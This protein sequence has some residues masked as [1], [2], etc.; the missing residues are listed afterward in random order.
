MKH[1]ECRLKLSIIAM[2]IF[3]SAIS[4]KAQFYTVTKTGIDTSKEVLS[5][6]YTS[7]KQRNSNPEEAVIFKSQPSSPYQKR[8]G[9]TRTGIKN[10]PHKKSLTQRERSL[11]IDHSL[12]RLPLS[13]PNIVIA[14]K[15]YNIQHPKIVLAQAIQETGWLNSNVCKTKNN[16]F[17]LTNP[18]TGEYYEF[19]HWSDSVRAYYTLVQYKYG[20]GNYYNWLEEI[21]YA[22]DPHYTQSLRKIVNQYL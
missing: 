12:H 11:P 17:G 14:L 22:G 10:Q 7:D 9:S 13:F 3:F 15:R 5:P 20:E 2:G 16:L 1:P 21:G 18:Y 6:A 4:A 8:E 19:E